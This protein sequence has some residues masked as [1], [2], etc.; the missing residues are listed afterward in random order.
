M[1]G[2]AMKAT[3]RKIS[4]FILL[5]LLTSCVPAWA[6]TWEHVTI[7]TVDGW[8]YSDMAVTGA[9]GQDFLTMI[10]GGGGRRKMPRSRIRVIVDA[11][12]RDISQAVFTA[13]GEGS[14]DQSDMEPERE[15]ISPP[16]GVQPPSTVVDAVPTDNDPSRRPLRSIRSQ[17]RFKFSPSLS[18]GYG[19]AGGPW[20]EGFTSGMALEGKL[21]VMFS[22]DSFMS[23]GYRH[24]GVGVDA[25]LD[26]SMENMYG[27]QFDWDVDL[28][29]YF[30]CGGVMSNPVTPTSL[31][32]YAEAGLG[33]VDHRVN[34][35]IIGDAAAQIEGAK[36]S[37]SESQLGI[38]LEGG[39]IIPVKTEVAIDLGVSLRMTSNGAS[40]S[41]QEA[42]GFVYGWRAGVAFLL[43][44]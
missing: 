30:V 1:V 12:G 24:Q 20:F 29:E 16:V 37:V 17:Q 34:V 6:T 43:G 18:F 27:A 8:E 35:V 36:V 19:Q 31:F 22:K 32:A 10:D 42:I 33:V 4:V 9:V 21:R 5:A 13:S 15:S 44:R 11:D 14:V 38:F 26:A 28:R 39:V 2:I 23:F 40:D 3:G 7:V 25:N 41:E